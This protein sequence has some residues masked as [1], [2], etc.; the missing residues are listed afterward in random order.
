[1]ENNENK[2]AL[3]E[4][5]TAP[6]ENKVPEKK[7]SAE[8]VIAPEKPVLIEVFLPKDSNNKQPY[9]GSING[10]KFTVQ[11]GRKVFL[12]EDQYAVFQ[13]S[14]NQDLY[15]SDLI[16]AAKEQAKKHGIV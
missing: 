14:V 11:R 1:M 16:D 6:E 5:A 9:I 2:K 8:K 15:V 12:T 13:N 7:K 10:K 4:A 3:D